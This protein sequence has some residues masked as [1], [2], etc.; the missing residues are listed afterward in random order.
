MRL[1]E[2]LFVL[3]N[4]A[5]RLLLRSPLHFLVSGSLMLIGFTGRRSGRRYST[6]V[7]YVRAGGVIRC[8]T[9]KDTQWWR[10][11]RGGAEVS[12]RLRGRELPCRAVAIDD[13]PVR[14]RAALESYFAEYPQDAAYHEVRLG[15][16]R[17]PQPADLERAAL[18]AVLVEAQPLQADAG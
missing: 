10:N 15:A 3:I 12:L 9:T 16:G 11:L 5:M 1:P 7:R 4:P 2:P 8:F 13:D 18:H 6:P 17:R 14:T